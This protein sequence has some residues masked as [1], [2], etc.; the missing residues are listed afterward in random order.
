MNLLLPTYEMA[1]NPPLVDF[2]GYANRIYEQLH[3]MLGDLEL[4]EC[5][6]QKFF[7]INPCMLPGFNRG[8]PSHGAHYF[9]VVSQPVIEGQVERR[10]DFMWLLETSLELIPV[11]IEIEKPSKKMFRTSDEVQNAKFTQACEQITEWKALLATSETRDCFYDR[12][13]VSERIRGLKFSPHYILVY[14]RR[15]EF[16]SDSFLA[17][18]RAEKQSSDFEIMSFDRLSPSRD[19]MHYG[20]VKIHSNGIVQVVRIPPTFQLGPAIAEDISNWDCFEDAVDTLENVSADRRAFLKERYKYWSNWT[21][22]PNK[23]VFE[24]E[25]WE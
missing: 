7:E 21:T 19:A 12:Y 6:Y 15:D 17:R 3:V 25:L 4:K 24:T 23:S 20:T 18:K 5:E 16:S 2:D 10:P 8:N 14:G 1:K 11:F 22:G 13:G 9:A